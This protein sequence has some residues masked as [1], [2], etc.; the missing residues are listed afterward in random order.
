[1]SILARIRANGGDVVRDKWRFALKRGRLSD[2]AL[3]WLRARWGEVR[4][5]VWPEFDA[6]AERAAIREYDGGQ[7]R[8]E[9]ERDAY[10]E[11]TEC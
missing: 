5:E 8:A 7:P 10:Q 2:D 4:L 6:F 1:M 9:A 3:V 11:V